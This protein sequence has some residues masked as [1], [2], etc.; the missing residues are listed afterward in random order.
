MGDRD[1]A[2]IVENQMEKNMEHEMEPG[3]MFRGFFKA[4]STYPAQRSLFPAN[5]KRLG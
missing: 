2:P 1:I 3:S 4:L 5:V